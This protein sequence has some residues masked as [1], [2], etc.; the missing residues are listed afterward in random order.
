MKKTKEEKELAPQTVKRKY[1][2]VDYPEKQN[3]A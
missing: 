1:D 2:N 3:L